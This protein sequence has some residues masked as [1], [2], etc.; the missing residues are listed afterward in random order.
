MLPPELDEFIAQ[1]Q[2]WAA[3]DEQEPSAPDDSALDA[4][5]SYLKSVSRYHDDLA[6]LVSR[7]FDRRDDAAVFFAL[8]RLGLDA[9]REPSL[10]RWVF[11]S[12]K[13]VTFI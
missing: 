4:F 3:R 5:D 12:K 8:D 6:A 9:L 1:G 2:L 13:S 10:Q 11:A 7:L